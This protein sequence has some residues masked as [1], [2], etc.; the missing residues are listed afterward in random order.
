MLRL[1]EK[2]NFLKILFWNVAGLLNKD[3]EFFKYLREFE[4]ICLTETWVGG[5]SWDKLRKNL[6]A[7]YIWRCLPAKKLKNKGRAKGGIVTGVRKEI[8]EKESREDEEFNLTENKVTLNGK[9]FRIFTVYMQDDTA[10]KMWEKLN[11]LVK[12]TEEEHLIIGGDMNARTGE[13]GDLFKPEV[14]M[15]ERKRNSKDKIINR[16]G[17][18]MLVE[19]ENRGWHICNGNVFDDIEGNFTYIGE[20]GSSTIDYVLVNTDALENLSGFKVAERCESDHLPL[21]VEINTPNLYKKESKKR[22]KKEIQ[23]WSE[24]AILK[25]QS[26][27]DNAII[28]VGNI[29]NS[30]DKLVLILKEAIQKKEIIIKKVEIGER[31]WWDRECQ[32]RKTKLN[33]A[34]RRAR[35]DH[36]CLKEFKMLRFEYKKFCKEKK[37]KYLDKID[38]EIRNIRTEN[39]VWQFINKERGRR[40]IFAENEIT[41][42]EWKAHFIEVLQ[43]IDSEENT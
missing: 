1:K 37:N 16:L 35:K 23:E 39:E 15:E 2:K 3:K 28:N 18:K 17:R 38:Q 19:V 13:V 41:Q 25:Y 30:L 8:D 20:R 14:N 40:K 43:G 7:E 5:N 21:I 9:K 33:Q 34:L 10:E 4:V 42:A 12:E 36:N 22:E 31:K 6:P 29:N 27:I 26:K 32:N 24:E 11:D